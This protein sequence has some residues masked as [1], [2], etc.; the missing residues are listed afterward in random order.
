MASAQAP[1]SSRICDDTYLLL[2]LER[3]DARGLV[4]FDVA[5]QSNRRMKPIWLEV[6]RGVSDIGAM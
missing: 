5:C 4:A 1:G 6:I 3:L 2:M